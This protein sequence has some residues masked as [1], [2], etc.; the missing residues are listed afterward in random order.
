MDKVLG[1]VLKYIHGQ[2][3][4]SIINVE[5]KIHGRDVLVCCF[6]N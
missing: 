6:T 2:L 1:C 3:Y 5:T 4:S